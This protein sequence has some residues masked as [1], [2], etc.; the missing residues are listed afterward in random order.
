MIVAFEGIDAC[1]KQT[2]VRMLKE[3]AE[4]LGHKT[5]VFSFPDYESPTGLK[6]KEL[7]RAEERDPL[8]L[9]SLMTVNRLEKQIKIEVA[10]IHGEL[11]ILDRY[12]L[13][14]WVYGQT[15]DLSQAWLTDIHEK[16]IHPHQWIILDIPVEESFRRRPVREDAYES[17]KAR[18][19]HARHLYLAALNTVLH[20]P[21][22]P[23]MTIDATLEPEAIHAQVLH[24]LEM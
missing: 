7:L 1:G 6:I 18:L 20:N 19:N 16:M 22:G 8:V 21:H 5:R 11:T 10:Q 2:Q 4:K 3:H 12:W 9:Q 13:S 23:C 14:G 15:D 24:C 17:S